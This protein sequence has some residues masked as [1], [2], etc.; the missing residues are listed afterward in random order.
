MQKWISPLSGKMPHT[1]LFVKGG[2]GSG[3]LG[4]LSSLLLPPVRVSVLG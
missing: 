4:L 2:V 1:H 3:S